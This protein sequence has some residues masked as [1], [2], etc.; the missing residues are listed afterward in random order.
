MNKTMKIEGMSCGHCTSAVEKVLRKI[1]GVAEV[2]VSLEEK[3][4]QI[5]LT[6]DV[7][8]EALRNAVTEEGFEVVSIA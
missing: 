6:K 5:T 1:D 7:P 4:A 8:E 3:S 2:T